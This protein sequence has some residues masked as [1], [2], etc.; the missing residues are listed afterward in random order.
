MQRNLRR[1]LILICCGL[2]LLSMGI[3]LGTSYRISE[4]DVTP[5]TRPVRDPVEVIVAEPKQI[6]AT[7]DLNAY[8][9]R[10]DEFYRKL[11]A[12][13]V[14]NKR[15]ED[16]EKLLEAYEKDPKA[17]LEQYTGLD[18]SF[19]FDAVI[20]AKNMVRIGTY[21]DGGKWVSDP[22]S[23]K[24]GAL[25]YSFGAGTEISFDTEIAGL[26]GC[27]VHC[28]DPTP[29]VELAFAKCRPAQQVGKGNF[30]FHAIGL[31]PVSNDPKSADEL[32]LEDKKC[33]VKRL[34]EIAAELGHTRIDILK[35]DI[36]G[37]EMAALTEILASG[38]LRK[39]EVKQLLVEFHLWSDEGWGSF[40]HIISELR[41][42]GYLIFRKEFNPLDTKCAEYCFLATK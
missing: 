40:V 27:E 35:I 21:A 42:Q 8:I 7:V 16:Q 4:I 39:L 5:P 18:R 13:Y 11:P 30:T 28:F 2:I 9:V 23:L 6:T 26:F 12:Q 38:L 24:A 25:V 36:E 20:D 31:G 32:V 19:L 10:R 37:G 29:S 22:H 34:G 3:W 14:Q 15:L 1:N 33:Q 41:R 17:F